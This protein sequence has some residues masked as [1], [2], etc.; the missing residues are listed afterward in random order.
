MKC[1]SLVYLN[2]V[3]SDFKEIFGIFAG[4]VNIKNGIFAVAD[5]LMDMQIKTNRSHLIPLMFYFI[6]HGQTFFGN[7]IP[8]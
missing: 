8:I 3:F 6:I 5:G 2:Q 7:F 1:E 4:I